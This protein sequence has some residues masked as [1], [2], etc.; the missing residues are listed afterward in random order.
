MSE[1]DF[2][3]KLRFTAELI[4]SAGVLRIFMGTLLFIMSTNVTNYSQK[5]QFA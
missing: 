1:L 2:N 4:L 3:T 5:A